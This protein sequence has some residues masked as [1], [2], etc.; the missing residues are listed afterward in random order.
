MPAPTDTTIISTPAS[1]RRAAGDEGSTTLSPSGESAQL[2]TFG[3]TW[4]LIQHSCSAVTA[5]PR[6]VS[7]CGRTA[8]KHRSRCHTDP[9]GPAQ[10]SEG[11][12]ARGPLPD[13]ERRRGRLEHLRV[14]DV[15]T[16]PQRRPAGHQD[17]WPGTVAGRASPVGGVHRA[18]V[19]TDAPL[20]GG[21]S[22]G[23]GRALPT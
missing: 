18:D 23:P 22:T 5:G 2:Y 4:L 7:G 10:P 16:G 9:A 11:R 14:A 15:C 13:A 6:R 19:R 8:G 20:R 1:S 17:R 3:G 12:D 21:T